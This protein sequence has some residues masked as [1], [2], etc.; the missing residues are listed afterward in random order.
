MGAMQELVDT[1]KIQFIG[2]SNFMLHELK[3]AQKAMTR[4]QIVSSQFG[5]TSSTERSTMA[6]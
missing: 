6:C 2:V 3:N 1:G 4:Y 5:I